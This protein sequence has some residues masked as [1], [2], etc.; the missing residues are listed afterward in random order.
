M[1]SADYACPICGTGGM[2]VFYEVADVPAS[3]NLLWTSKNE[4]VNCPKGNIKLAFCSFC[5]LVTNIA[6]EP[7]KNQYGD[8]YDSSLFY[9]SHF[10]DFA[11][12]LAT[13]L[14]QRYDLHDKRIIEIGGGKVDFLSLLID[15]GHNHGLRFDPFRT[16]VE[17]N[18]RK[19]N[20]LVGSIPDFYRQID[21]SKE[22]SFIF[23]YH[24]LE[25][26]NYPKNFLVN[27][28]NMLGYSPNSHVFFAVPNA[29][30]AFENGDFTN[31]IYE[32]VSYFTAPSLVYLFLPAGLKS[33][34]LRSPKMKSSTQFTL[35]PPPRPE[36]SQA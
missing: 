4:A 13:S 7:G 20:D 27:L 11:I 1:I 24:E 18:S 19:A 29:L 34:K 12:K 33:A 22:A 5:T 14:V 16:K 23:C 17:D 6:I 3:C 15:F 30:K 10:Q 35:M 25:H 8:R 28:R 9:S 31:I 32:H 36:Q 26:M 2:S 21:G